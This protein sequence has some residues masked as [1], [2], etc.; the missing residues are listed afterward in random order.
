MVVSS[1]TVLPTSVSEPAVSHNALLI[2]AHPDHTP[3][4]AQGKVDPRE[5]GKQGGNSSGSTDDSNDNSSENTSN[6]GSGKGRK[7]YTVK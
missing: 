2:F 1:R 4:F 7:F 6:V 3:E 5:A